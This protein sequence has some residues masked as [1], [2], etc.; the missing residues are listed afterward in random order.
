MKERPYCTVPMGYGFDPHMTGRPD[1]E[2]AA[3]LKRA[4]HVGN[5]KKGDYKK[6][7]MVLAAGK[8]QEAARFGSISLSHSARATLLAAPW[9][10]ENSIDMNPLGFDTPTELIAAKQVIRAMNGIPHAVTSWWH[11]PRTYL[12][13][14]AIFG[15]R[16]KV[17]M[18]HTAL[19]GAELRR[20]I[21][22]EAVKLVPS[23]FHALW[24]RFAFRPE[25]LAKLASI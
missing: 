6:V 2:G 12:T 17:S 5:R 16:F 9:W 21:A 15:W 3:R 13:G 24:T 19:R 7:R 10:E 22:M 8:Q 18:S 4:I 11:A 1:R 14:L 25:P 20:E 23:F